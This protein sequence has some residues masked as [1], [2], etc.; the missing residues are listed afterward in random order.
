MADAATHTTFSAAV[1]RSECNWAWS[2]SEQGDADEA[3][4]R[5]DALIDRLK[6]T[7]TFDAAFQLAVAQGD[8]GR[9]HVNTGHAARAIPILC[10][11]VDAWEQLVRQAANLSPSATIEDLITSVTQD[12]RQRRE[13]CAEQLNNWAASLSSLANALRD[14][15]RLDEALS[16][17]EQSVGI[18]RALGRDRNAVATL[19]QTAHIL[20]LQGHYQK[21]DARLGQG[22]EAAR[23]LGDQALEGTILQHQGALATALQQYDR[24][25]NLYRQALRRFQDAS[26]DASIMRT[27]NQLG[28]VEQKAGRLAE[29]RAWYERSREIARRRGDTRFLDS[30]AQNIGIVCQ[31]E[32]EAARQ[33]GD[34]TTARQQ[35]SE[36]ERFLQESL[37][38]KVERQDK[39]DEARAQ[40]ELSRIYLLM[41][42][43]DKAEVHAHLA[44]E[45]DE[46]L[47]IIRQLPQRLLQPRP[48]RPCA[49]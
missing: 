43:L 24:A 22:L 23:R 42:E 29:A 30:T 1:A 37:R 21:A 11:A 7:T 19:G 5:L 49:R 32:G 44:R 14:A 39:P 25:V 3:V 45:I 15:G 36:A 4:R 28:I 38:L 34:E 10:E 18:F 26:D 27:C 35:F 8:L 40:T 17:A 12:A 16:T 41:G 33:R 46:G 2:L 13:A 47:G 48:N 20:T 6:Q 31:L 9:I